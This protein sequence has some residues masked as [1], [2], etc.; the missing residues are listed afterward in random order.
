MARS[1]LIHVSPSTA[2]PDSAWV[3]RQARNRALALDRRSPVVRFLIRDRARSSAGRSPGYDPATDPDRG[4]GLRFSSDDLVDCE[5]PITDEFVVPEDADSGLYAALVRLA[6]QD[7]KD[8]VPI[9]FAVVRTRPRRPASVALLLSTTT[10]YAYGRRPADEVR[11]AGL[12]ASFYS[13][14]LNGRPFFQVGL[15]APIP[16]ANP[17]GFDSARAEHTGSSH[18]VRP[19][20]Y[21]EAAIVKCCG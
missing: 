20:R 15:Q 2:Y 9:V 10:W 5:W 3:T 13:S 16:R 8:A 12:A 19:E 1:P 17:Y 7:P 11:V 4:H 6:G 21:A 18:L 14:H